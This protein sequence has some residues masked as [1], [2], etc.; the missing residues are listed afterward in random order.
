MSDGSKN[1]RLRIVTAISLC[2]SSGCR[3]V[4]TTS[5]LLLLLLLLLLF[6]RYFIA[7]LF[8]FQMLSLYYMQALFRDLRDLGYHQLALPVVAMQQLIADL[9]FDNSQLKKLVHLR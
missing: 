2:N 7:V 8:S 9:V 5:F 1:P 6:D 3:F 4:I